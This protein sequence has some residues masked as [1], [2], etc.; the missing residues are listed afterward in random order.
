[1]GT[2]TERKFL[3]IGDGWRSSSSAVFYRQGYIPTQNQATVRV[4]RAGDRAY[5]TVKGPTVGITRAEY[6][7]EI[8]CD[9][10][11]AMLNN[12]CQH[13]LIEKHRHTLSSD[14][15]LWEVDEFRGEN[16]GLILAEVEL[17]DLDQQVTLPDWVG[18]EVSLDPRYFNAN[19][20]RQPYGSWA[21]ACGQP[22]TDSS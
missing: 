8:P 4:R 16:Q 17:S 3:V 1:M 18:E 20:A 12:L 2:E 15:V 6:E 10:A 21:E 5:L 11:D 19:L 7:Y 9:D 14:G 13:P 22:R